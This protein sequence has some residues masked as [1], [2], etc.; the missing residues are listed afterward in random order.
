MPKWKVY[1]SSTF[2]DLKDFRFE[3][4]NLFQNQ[5][6][7]NFELSEI[8]ERMFDDGTYA[9]FVDDCVEAVQ[10][11]D[12]YIIILGNRT[13]SFPPDE[14]R[15][16]TEIEL[17]T[18]LANDKYI[19][20]LRLE[21]FDEAI[22][23]NK[24]KHNELLGKFDG[25][26]IHTFKDLTELKNILFECLIPFASESPI[27]NKNPYKGLASFEVEDGGY[28]FG[29]D[30][31]LED[32]LKKIITKSGP[33][34]ISVIGNSGT[35]KSS[36]VRAG[37]LYR[38][39]KREELGFS[40]HLQ[41]IIT[42][43]SEPFTNLKYQLK[44]VGISD[45]E[46]LSNATRTAKLIL[47]FDQFEEVITQCNSPEGLEERKQLFDFLEEVV[48]PE[49]TV[50]GIVVITTFR[51]DFLSQLA[52]FDFVKNH[53]IIF[54]ISS[55]DYKVHAPNWQQSMEEIITRP[56]L[57]NGVV[58]EKELVN[59]IT[60]QIKEVEGSLSIL[61][62]T[63][64]RIWNQESIADRLISTTEFS[65]ISEG[66]G[67]AGIIETHA[68]QVVKRITNH[69][70]DK[71]K[72]A[73]LKSIFVNLVEVN[74]NLLDVKRTVLKTDLYSILKMYPEHIIT[75][76]FEVLVSEKSRL[77]HVFESKDTSINVSI[78]HEVLI[79]KWD[80]LKGWIDERREALEQKKRIILD[81]AAFKKGEERL[82]YGRKQLARAR[83]W[84]T[85]NPDLCN[86]E[87]DTFLLQAKKTLNSKIYRGTGII[88]FLSIILF[89]TISFAVL[90]RQ[91]KEFIS[92]I[93]SLVD[94]SLY[95]EFLRYGRNLDSI[96]TVTVS[97]FTESVLRGNLNLFENL[98]HLSILS[99]VKGNLDFLNGFKNNIRIDTVT[100]IENNSLT[101]LEGIEKLTN[102]TSLT[103]DNN[104][105]LASL[106]GLKNLPN[107]TSLTL[108][109]NDSLASL[110]GLKNLPKLTSLT[111]ERNSG[112]ASLE[113]LER[114]NGLTS[115]T[116]E[117]NSGLASLEGLERL[118]GLTTLTLE[119]NYSVTSLD[120]IEKLTNLTSLTLDNN[121]SLAS[122]EGI[123]KLTNLTSLTLEGNSGL[124]SLDGIEK[125][126]SLNYLAILNNYKLH[127]LTGI[128]QLSSLSELTVTSV[129]GINNLKSL[130]D[131]KSL[132][133]LAL[134][135]NYSLRSLKGIE[136][137][138]GLT[139]LTLFNNNRLTSLDGIEKLTNLTS[140]TLGGNSGLTSLEGLERLNGLTSLTLFNNNS[141]T[142]LERL[143]KLTNLTSLTLEGNSGLASLDGIEKLT[144]LTSLTLEGNSG[145]ASLDGIEKLTNLTSLILEGNS[146]LASLEGL[147]KLTN[148][149]SLILE[150]NSGLASL[151]G[152]EGLNGLTSLT[153][154]RNYG[155][156]SLD[157]IEKLTNLTSLTLDNNDSLTS[158]EGIEKLTNLTSLTLGDNS[159]LKSIN[160]IV[161]LTSLISLSVEKE[162]YEE[163]LIELNSFLDRNRSCKVNCNIDYD[164]YLEFLID[165]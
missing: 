59:E 79:R 104:I 122:L 47:F 38:L 24:T 106:E 98:N 62:F 53:Q 10:S 121:D 42:P 21:S 133:T 124:T 68:E 2:R 72:E 71:V 31:E 127:R 119:R 108:D 34:N 17:D 85:S 8:M 5:L 156:T 94:K 11:S 92:D 89:Y 67:I 44:L 130:N 114:L 110:E 131:I 57:K 149:T 84:S 157:G 141:L 74:E 132:N 66:K 22:I 152:L 144:N 148:L 97:P 111:L 101:S 35:G 76:I 70:R 81:I 19:F 129:N 160:S 126:T 145:L 164:N 146:G 162:I 117:R 45:E 75:E 83:K 88:I 80:R 107:L 28:F 63:L 16:Y 18:A 91:K 54:P 142:S 147:E 40:D 61:Q 48:D 151:E 1:I 14:E 128:E 39:K 64:Q 154:E 52:N 25:R 120:G 125:L 33:S 30:Q 26:P 100:I 158:L 12:I 69:G 105:G 20:C 82:L 65:Q 155:L 109:N 135:N 56:A 150:G 116:L 50:S 90:N 103:L 13:G 15:T 102:L 46:V 32:C 143:K 136:N 112:L 137:L 27:N 95:F 43:G 7:N 96:K 159:G 99:S 9:P 134:K 78:I 55:L 3:L 60:N 87:I 58:I 118:N 73:I 93:E 37:L 140:L 139:S 41:I 86:E 153:L 51:S 77:I 123:K 115:L 29:R 138:T 23:D 36:F 165:L 6:K 161:N 49:R 4:I 113:G 163:H